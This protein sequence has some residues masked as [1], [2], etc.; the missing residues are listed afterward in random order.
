MDDF[1]NLVNNFTIITID[2][3]TKEKIIIKLD[4]ANIHYTIH[5]GTK[6]K[7][8]DIHKTTELKNGEKSYETLYKIKHFTVGRIICEIKKNLNVIIN[9]L[10]KIFFSFKVNPSFFK[11][12]NIIAQSL[13]ENDLSNT[14]LIDFNTKKNK[15]KFRK[16][17]NINETISL[18]SIINKETKPSVYLLWKSKKN[19]FLKSGLLLVTSCETKNTKKFYFVTKKSYNSFLKAIIS[20]IIQCLENN[21][22]IDQNVYSELKKIYI[23]NY[24]EQFQF[25]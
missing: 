2:K 10:E 9:D 17:A 12:H 8:I 23:K 14:Q 3:E 25:S 20:K 18:L 1:Q 13:D 5:F 7:V 4:N 11:H 19:K 22:L 24:N 16:N 15:L 21:T 6:S